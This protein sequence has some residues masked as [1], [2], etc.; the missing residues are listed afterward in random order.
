MTY[1]NI[2]RRYNDN[3]KIDKDTIAQ[4]IH[5]VVSGELRNVP[6]DKGLPRL[7]EILWDIADQVNVSGADIFKIY[8]DW[9]SEHE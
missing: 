6:F 5:S 9:L 8:M 3:G 1:Y 7:R 2:S 4:K